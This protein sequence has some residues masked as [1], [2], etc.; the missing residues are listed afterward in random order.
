MNARER[1]VNIMNYKKADA[2]PVMLFE[3]HESFTLNEWRKQGMP[4]DMTPEEFF[5]IDYEHKLQ[6]HFYPLPPF[7]RTIVSEEPEYYTEIECMGSTVRRKRDAPQMT[8]GHIAYPV[9]D[10][11]SFLRYRERFT[12][13]SARYQISIDEIAAQAQASRN[14][15][16]LSLFPFFMR[17]GFY[18]MG[19]ERF[20]TSFYDDPD[21]IH[22]MFD[23]WA[24]FIIDTIAPVLAKVTPDI[25]SFG[26][27]LAYKNGPHMSPRIYKE[28]WLPHQ[29][30]VMK[31]VKDAG[32]PFVCMYT[33]GDVR[34]LLPMMLE[35]GFNMTWPLDQYSNMDPLALRKEYG[36]QLRMT[37]GISKSTLFEG[38]D[39]ID[40]RLEELAPLIAEG[41]FIPA[42]DDMIPPEIPL[43][44]FMYLVD[45]LK[46][47]QWR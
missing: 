11:D 27:D 32:V 29:N 44:H 40:R 47:V 20:L 34:P 42:P 22:E 4:D 39:A 6:I 30:R 23:F 24:S 2:L 15:V 43:K 8:Y 28:F 45:K 14:P 41:G 17:L 9:H 37:G 31:A 18:S 36:R 38:P 46:Q 1:F 5:G 25:A 3:P 26:E 19:L 10:R 35:N 16:T 21:L 7:E 12:T 13:E 33:S